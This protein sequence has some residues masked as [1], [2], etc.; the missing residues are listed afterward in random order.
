M[1]TATFIQNGDS[2]DYTPS[3][4]VSAGDVIVL[5]DLVAIAKKDIADGVLGAL[6]VTGVF[7]VPKAAGQ[8]DLG[9]SLYWNECSNTASTDYSDIY[10]GKAAAN[11]A[12]EAATCLVKLCP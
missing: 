5:N 11:A 8:I 2:I 10:M 1:A 6:A 9:E 3:G 4:S 7:E 12:T